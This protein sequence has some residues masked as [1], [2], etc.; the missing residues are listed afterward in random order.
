[1]RKEHL[2]KEHLAK[3]HVA[4]EHVAMCKIDQIHSGTACAAPSD[5]VERA[6]EQAAAGVSDV[7]PG[8]QTDRRTSWSRH[9]GDPR[10][11]S[12]ALTAIPVPQPG[13]CYILLRG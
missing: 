13:W 2:A 9:V 11:G 5:M 6:I 10:Y 4:K 1:V 7:S 12:P 3:E 8:D